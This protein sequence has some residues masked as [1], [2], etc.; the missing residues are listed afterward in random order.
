MVIKVRL[1]WSKL[2]FPKKTL[3][4]QHNA[5][6]VVFKIYDLVSTTQFLLTS[7]LSTLEIYNAGKL[8]CTVLQEMD[9]M[10]L[11]SDNSSREKGKKNNNVLASHKLLDSGNN[12]KGFWSTNL[13][14][15]KAEVQ[16]KLALSSWGLYS[17][18]AS[19]VRVM[20]DTLD[21]ASVQIW[22][23]LSLFFAIFCVFTNCSILFYLF[24]FLPYPTLDSASL[25]I[26]VIWQ[27]CKYFTYSHLL[28]QKILHADDITWR[29]H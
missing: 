27:I 10:S 26:R 29:K 24:L 6:I 1:P 15:G 8:H 2:L 17:T 9:R 11:N 19:S 5:L 4:L 14:T 25:I 3:H 23:N 7:F 22:E 16:K 28:L 20:E 13:S 18:W 12:M 21:L